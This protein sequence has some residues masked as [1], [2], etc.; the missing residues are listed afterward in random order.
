MR[1]MYSED[2]RSSVTSY[3]SP[4]HSPN[5]EI[6]FYISDDQFESSTGHAKQQQQRPNHQSP[7]T[8]RVREQMRG[9][10][11]V[12][13]KKKKSVR[14][15]RGGIQHIYL[16]VERKHQLKQP[17]SELLLLSTEFFRLV[18]SRPTIPNPQ[19][20]CHRS[21]PGTGT[22]GPSR[23]SS[24]S[25]AASTACSPRT[26]TPGAS[27]SSSTSGAVSTE[28]SPRTGYPPRT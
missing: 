15:V 27:R 20:G 14:S 18:R 26:G 3:L 23:S 10:L 25:G 4:S 22:P 1:S 13:K 6:R 2:P 21:A 5:R 11:I 9:N 16:P 24:P 28:C 8:V 12:E 19:T 7:V 17:D